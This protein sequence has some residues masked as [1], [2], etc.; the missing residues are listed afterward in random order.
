MS[1][2]AANAGKTNYGIG[3]NYSEGYQ[4]AAGDIASSELPF[5]QNELT[6]PQGFGQQTLNQMQTSSGQ[7]T[8]GALGA[9]KE[10]AELNASRTG[11]TAAIPGVIDATTRSGMQQQSNNALDIAQKNALLKQ[12]QQQEGAA[13]LE[14]MY[15]TDVSAALQALGL[16][17]QSIGEWNTGQT[18]AEN[19]IQQWY[20]DANQGSLT[21]A[22]I[23]AG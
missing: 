19:N 15:G 4:G 10:A 17:N 18:A 20:Q 8:A 6:N 14:K 7:A 13:G 11:N 16:S 23:A 9:G 5:L 2:G 1:K 12:Q 21:G 3:Q 22:K